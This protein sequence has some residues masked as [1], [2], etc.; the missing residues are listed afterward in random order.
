MITTSDIFGVAFLGGIF[1][2]EQYDDILNNSVGNIQYAAD[3]LQKSFIEGLTHHFSDLT[4]I[5]LPFIGSW[6][7]RYKSCL[8]PKS[9]QLRKTGNSCCNFNN[10][11]FVNI[12]GIKLLSRYLIAKQSIKHYCK[13]SKAAN[14][15]LLLYSVHT[16]FLKAAIDI[17]RKL[18]NLQIILIVPDLPEYMGGSNN[19]AL[20]IVRNY[21][22]RLLSKLYDKVDG[23]VL[24]S[25]HMK[26][27]LV[28]KNQPYIVIEGIFNVNDDI[29]VSKEVHDK[30]IILYSGTFARRYNIMDLV[31]AVHS[32]KRDD[33]VLEI[34]GEGDARDEIESITQMDRRIKYCG[35]KPREFILRRQKEADLLV[36][37]R[38][39]DG[40]YTK[41][42]FPSK[43]MEYLASGTATLIYQLPGIPYEYYNHCFSIPKHTDKSLAEWIDTILDKDVNELS[44]IGEEARKFILDNK[45]PIMQTQKIANLIN[46]LTS[47]GEQ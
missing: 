26:D 41:Y 20:S 31:Y 24:L 42:S 4:I 30:K 23:F 1:P 32:L 34:Y 12:A 21:N 25:D 6:P 43:T 33:F 15:I 44:K 16:P 8:S 29:S 45:N 27:R 38:T 7:K 18:S 40:E 3:A 14:N 13:C 47:T 35:Q 22:H 5:N 17:K 36:N 28:K 9:Y 46:N 2:L 10:Y 19:E 37:P 39:S 11:R